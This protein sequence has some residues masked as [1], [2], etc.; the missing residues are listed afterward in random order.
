VSISLFVVVCALALFSTPAWAAFPGVNG[1]IALSV[2]GINDFDIYK[3]N[4]DGTARADLTNTTETRE[5]QPIWSPDGTKISYVREFESDGGDDFRAYVMDADGSHARL[6]R[7]GSPTAATWTPDGK[8]L[9]LGLFLYGLDGTAAGRLFSDIEATWSAY[10]PDGLLIAYTTS[11]G[12]QLW[13]MNADGTDR[14]QLTTNAVVDADWSPD[15]A[16]L[17]FTNPAPTGI[18]LYTVAPKATLNDTRLLLAESFDLPIQ[19]PV[20]WSPDGAKLTFGVW[21]CC[22]D[23]RGSDIG[24]VDADGTNLHVIPKPGVGDYDPNWGTAEGTHEPPVDEVPAK[25]APQPKTKAPP[26]PRP[27]APFVRSEDPL[28]SLTKTRASAEARKALKHKY[29]QSYTRGK[30]KQL[31]CKKQTATR[32]R[33]AFSFKSRKRR[34]AGTVTV[35]VNATGAATAVVRTA[36]TS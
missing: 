27:S 34:R 10:S 21:D 4:P 5:H 3:M 28:G 2:L 9:I 13:T 11:P 16:L 1:Q 29:G 19:G 7:P 12:N 18:G 31:I 20:S 26:A 14:R 36:R 24:I 32:Y 15:G 8:Q 17:A 25:V 35:E 23:P 30:R 22:A 33:C 6:I